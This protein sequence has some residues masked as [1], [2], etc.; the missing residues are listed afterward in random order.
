[1]SARHKDTADILA[2]H[3]GKPEALAAE[4]FRPKEAQSPRPTTP[5]PARQPV[6]APAL[7]PEVEQALTGMAA[8]LRSLRSTM[9]LMAEQMNK[10]VVL[11]SQQIEAIARLAPLMVQSSDRI[12]DGLQDLMSAVRSIPRPPDAASPQQPASGIDQHTEQKQD[13]SSEAEPTHAIDAASPGTVRHPSKNTGRTRTAT[14][15][16]VVVKSIPDAKRSNRFYTTI[17]VPRVLW[18]N[19]GFHPADRVEI[20]WTGKALTVKR[21][22]EGGVKP[23]AISDSAVIL[24]SWR[25]GNLNFDQPKVTGANASL[26]LTMAQ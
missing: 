10:L 17:R 6:S 2:R 7:S 22:S 13:V 9:E 24:Q 21:V 8:D 3:L 15:T 5:D 25:L 18:D 23:K 4:V 1:M 12:S 16:P 19:S 20:D 11:G 14:T 26:R